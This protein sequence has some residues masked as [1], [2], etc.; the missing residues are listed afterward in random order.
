MK[1][2]WNKLWHAPI[3]PLLEW[4]KWKK[5][6]VTSVRTWNN[7]NSHTLQVE[8]QMVQLL[9]KTVDICHGYILLPT[10]CILRYTTNRNPY[11]GHQ[12]YK[13]I[14]HFSN[15][16][17]LENCSSTIEWINK[18]SYV[19]KMGFYIAIKFSIVLLCT[20]TFINLTNITIHE[21]C[22]THKW[23]W[24]ITLTLYKSTRMK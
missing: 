13:N 22:Q 10:S 16:Q 9:W 4:L 15:N 19:H 20:I 18:F 21:W 23:I 11:C 14:Q 2:R 12:K 3:F 5:L 24:S 17:K 7:W 8:V 6:R 1:G